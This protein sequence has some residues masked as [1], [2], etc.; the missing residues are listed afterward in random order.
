MSDLSISDNKKILTLVSIDK[1]MFEISVDDLQLSSFIKQLLELDNN[2][3][4]I[5]IQTSGYLLN[6]IVQFL[7]YYR[8]N[9][10]NNILKPIPKNFN[11]ILF[12]NQ[13]NIIF[14]EPFYIKLLNLKNNKL[15]F[16]LIRIVNYLSI[17]QLLELV[18]AKLANI[19]HNM[20][21]EEQLKYLK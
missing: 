5:P 16:E 15:L 17:E 14:S 6:I 19:L 8:K 9:P 3:L 11:N 1:Q 12:I 21:N 4:K 20:T 10:F 18:S 7:K 2:I 13:D